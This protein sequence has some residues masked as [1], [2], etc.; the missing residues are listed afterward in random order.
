MINIMSV[1]K[2]PDEIDKLYYNDEISKSEVFKLR[3]AWEKST[4]EVK[5]R[6]LFILKV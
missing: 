6:M 4:E 1:I 2:H 3:N 5:K